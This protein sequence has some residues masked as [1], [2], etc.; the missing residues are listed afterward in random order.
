MDKEIKKILIKFL[1]VFLLVV[2]VILLLK[3]DKNYFLLGLVVFAIAIVVL[4]LYNIK[5]EDFC[6]N[7]PEKCS[8]IKQSIS[9]NK[10]KVKKKK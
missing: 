10:E 5:K 1:G 4:I 2:S 7:N 3:Q 8:V 9:E 6:S